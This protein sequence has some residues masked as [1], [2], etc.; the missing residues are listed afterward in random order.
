MPP[1]C[2]QETWWPV[3]RALL[4]E[5]LSFGWGTSTS[6]NPSSYH[7]LYLFSNSCPSTRTFNIYHV[8]VPRFLRRQVFCFWSYFATRAVFFWPLKLVSVS[9]RYLSYQPMGEKIKTSTLQFFRQRKPEYGEGIVRLAN[10]VAV[11]RQR[12]VSIDFYKVLR[13]EVFSIER[14]LNQLKAT[15]VCIRLINQSNRSI[16]AH[17]LFLFSFQGHTKIALFKSI[18]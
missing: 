15:R 6:Y 18:T 4:N 13:H 9:V 12:E 1:P 10:R 3:G 17:L 11:W 7:W 14:S 5:L 2:N 8:A 16:S